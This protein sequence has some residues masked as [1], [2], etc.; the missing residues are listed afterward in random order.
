M[1]IHPKLMDRHLPKLI[2]NYLFTISCLPGTEWQ[3]FRIAGQNPKK[4][5]CKEMFVY[6][7][8]VLLFLNEKMLK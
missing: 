2:Y 3:K 5:K 1:A 8:S 6:F 4:N 7:Y